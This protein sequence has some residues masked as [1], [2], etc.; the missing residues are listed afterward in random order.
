MSVAGL[1]VKGTWSGILQVLKDH[2]YQPKLV[3]KATVCH[4]CTINKKVL[5]YR[6]GKINHVLQA[7]PLQRVLETEEWVNIDEATERWQYNN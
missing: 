1:K 5:Q 7:R 3:Y 4:S 2:R 6:T